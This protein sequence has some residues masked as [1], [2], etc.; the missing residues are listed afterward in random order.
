MSRSLYLSDEFNETGTC[1]D[2]RIKI[3]IIHLTL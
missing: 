3:L 2:L 1:F